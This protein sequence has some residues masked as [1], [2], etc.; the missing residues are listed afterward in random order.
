MTEHAAAASGPDGAADGRRLF[1]GWATIW[2]QKARTETVRQRLATDPHSPPEF[3]CNQIVANIDAFHDA[4]D[5]G[6][7]DDLWLAPEQR[8]RIW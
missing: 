3:R 7:G 2:R 5:V 4:F 8:V 1:R 6:A